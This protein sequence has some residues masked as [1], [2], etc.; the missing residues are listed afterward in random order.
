MILGASTATVSFTVSSLPGLRAQ[1]GFYHFFTHP[2]CYLR[3][4]F[5]LSFLVVGLALSTKARA[6]HSITA[7]FPEYFS[8]CF[9]RRLE[10]SCAYPR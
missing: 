5:S 7:I 6:L 4:S 1:A 3:P 10:L 8:S 9:P 2:I